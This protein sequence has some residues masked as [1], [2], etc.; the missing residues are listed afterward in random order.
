MLSRFFVYL[1][2]FEPRISVASCLRLLRA[3]QFAAAPTRRTAAS[4]TPAA[5][6]EPKAKSE[7]HPLTIPIIA[8]IRW[9]DTVYCSPSGLHGPQPL[10]RGGP[11]LFACAHV[12]VPRRLR[13]ENAPFE[14]PPLMMLFYYVTFCT[15]KR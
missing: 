11:L 3:A 8:C 4:R 7:N 12:A 10:P 9:L 14:M 1:R 5:V 6:G 13:P 15:D 2:F